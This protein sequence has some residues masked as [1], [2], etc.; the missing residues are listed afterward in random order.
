MFQLCVHNA[1]KR[2]ISW[3]D[4]VVMCERMSN[5]KVYLMLNYSGELACV[6]IPGKC[7]LFQ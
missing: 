5:L 3:E 7:V 6:F 2:P 1:K 4:F